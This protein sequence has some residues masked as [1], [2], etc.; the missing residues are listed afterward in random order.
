[1]SIKTAD[2]YELETT[3]KKVV[4]AKFYCKIIITCNVK[5]FLCLSR[6]EFHSN[7]HL[8]VSDGALLESHHQTLEALC[9]TLF[10]F[11]TCT[12]TQTIPLRDTFV[13]ALSLCASSVTDGLL[14]CKD[15]PKEGVEICL[16]D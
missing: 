16:S 15:H 6:R 9:R 13:L 5:R 7:F 8:F 4:N 3:F 11:A 2:E 12:F 1:M 10:D 14:R